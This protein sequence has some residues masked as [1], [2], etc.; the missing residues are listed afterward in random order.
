MMSVRVGVK[1][2]TDTRATKQDRISRPSSL[3]FE[4][5]TS[6]FIRLGP[7]ELVNNNIG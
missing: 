3:L 4:S 6:T 1:M 2:S 7:I 5:L